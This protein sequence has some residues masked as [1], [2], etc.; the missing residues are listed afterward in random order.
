[1]HKIIICR[2]ELVNA[3]VHLQYLTQSVVPVGSMPWPLDSRDV[4]RL[5]DG[6]T[7]ASRGTEFVDLMWIMSEGVLSWKGEA[8]WL[9]SMNA[10]YFSVV[11]KL[12]NG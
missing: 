8:F 4:S 10:E 12:A 1:M 6:R 3:L 11:M 2:F 9:H 7:E 5:C